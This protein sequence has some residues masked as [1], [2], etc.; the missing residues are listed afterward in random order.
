MAVLLVWDEGFD[1]K[2]S[3]YL[4]FVLSRKP[5]ECNLHSIGQVWPQTLIIQASL[6]TPSVGKSNG[7]KF[8]PT[9]F[10]QKFTN[11]KAKRN[12]KNVI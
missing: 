7:L 12:R 8:M 2:I 6:V 4:L 9:K 11:Y 5:K 1:W 3:K 10:L